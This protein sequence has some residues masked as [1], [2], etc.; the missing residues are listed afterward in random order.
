MRPKLT[1]ASQ[2]VAVDAGLIAVAATE[3][4]LNA[5]P[6]SSVAK[7]VAGVVGVLALFVRRRHRYV[8]FFFTLPAV[9]MSPVTVPA[10][11]ALYTVARHTRDRRV[12]ALCAAA[13]AIADAV[14]SPLNFHSP[15]GRDLL[16]TLIYSTLLGAAPAFLG[17][18]VQAR[19]DLAVRLEEIIEA[20]EHGQQLAAQ[21]VLAE[22]RAQL[23]REM[24]DVVAHQVSLIA[25]QAAALQVTANPPEATAAG[26]IRELAVKTLDELR[27]MI[28]PLRA[29]ANRATPLAPQPTLTDL[30]TLITDSGI[31]ATL[32]G[33]LPEG[34]DA[35][36]QRAIYRTVQEGLTNAR[37]HAPGARVTVEL[38]QDP[39][40]VGVTVTNGPST[41][42]PLALPSAH[43]GLIG[44][45]ERAKLLSGTL[46]T[47]YVDEGGFRI[48][49]RLPTTK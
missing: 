47:E 21:T 45:R 3:V 35:T 17:Q 25:V 42:R 39:D 29:S 49:L 1:D 30:P 9:I 23:A 6:P 5:V 44:L 48:S 38:W 26:T 22:E 2:P 34:V 24:H 10:L 28:N 12:V 31:D 7:T 8:A 32:Q 36:A 19:A 4:A 33:E 40:V 18:L 16:I 15:G 27:H 11:I 46:T 43:H 37:K 13:V 41:R 20:R 14:P